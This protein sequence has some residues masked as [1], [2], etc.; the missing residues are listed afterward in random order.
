MDL[1]S[2]LLAPILI[3]LILVVPAGIIS[4]LRYAGL[5]RYRGPMF[6]HNHAEAT[7]VRQH[8]QRHTQHRAVY[9][10][11]R[12]ED[13]SVIR[14]V[15]FEPDS[16]VAVTIADE[17]V[18]AWFYRRNINGALILGDGLDESVRQEFKQESEASQVGS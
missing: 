14:N 16:F 8:W 2:V 11:V 5:P 7:R 6:P 18:P 12:L 13:G 17:A 4:Y 10:D 1:I 3:M 9:A 15:C